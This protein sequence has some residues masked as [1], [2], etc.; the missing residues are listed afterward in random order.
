MILDMDMEAGVGLLE[1]AM[2]QE[3]DRMIFER[4]IQ[5][6]QYS[7]SF[8]DFKAALRPREMKPE[9]VVLEDVGNILQA[10]ERER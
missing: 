3:T 9:H 10:F 6:A 1:Y 2:E 8:D 5:G 4:W 7:Q